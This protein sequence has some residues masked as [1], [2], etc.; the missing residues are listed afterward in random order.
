MDKLINL[1]VSILITLLFA[2]PAFANEESG[3]L[4]SEQILAH[5]EI[6][7]ALAFMTKFREFRPV[8]SA[9]RT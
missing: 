6:K 9:I 1:L 7:G 4:T 5:P 2:Y 8:L 3:Q